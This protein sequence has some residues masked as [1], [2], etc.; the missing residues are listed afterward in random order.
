MNR[1]PIVTVDMG[2]YGEQEIDF[3]DYLNISSDLVSELHKDAANFAYISSVEVAVKNAIKTKKLEFDS[4]KG[5]I[6]E[7]IFTEMTSDKGKKPT[8]KEVDARLATDDTLVRFQQEIGALE[9]TLS[10]IVGQLRAMEH[11]HSNL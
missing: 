1:L 10:V 3:N 2:A 7:D 8:V 4:L 11:K 9:N 5:E 6:T